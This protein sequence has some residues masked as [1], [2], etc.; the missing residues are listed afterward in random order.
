M[1]QNVPVYAHPLELPY[2]NDGRRYPPGDP[3]VGGAMAQMSRFMDTARSTPT[4]AKVM[5]LPEEA[6]PF[7]LMPGWE[8]RP[9]PGHTPGHVSFW[10]AATRT[11]IAGDA[12]V[13]LDQ[14]SPFAVIAQSP[15]ISPPPPYATYNW[16]HARQSA[17]ALAELEPYYLC[18]GHGLPM[19]G[20][21]IADDLKAFVKDFP[22]PSR[23]RYVRSPVRF[24][25][26]GPVFIPP[27]AIDYV[28]YAAI[29]TGILGLGV[30]AYFVTR[31]L[32][33]KND[34]D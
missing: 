32:R 7:D 22:T 19:Q 9:T 33:H 5:P 11:L 15:T 1:W 27:P 26:E 20:L 14:N 29:T 23:G 16:N 6:G 28:K 24:N 25:R 17:R 4:P 8:L 18:T 30:A 12:V 34:D 10:N 31:S 21:S 2:L 3:T 13:T